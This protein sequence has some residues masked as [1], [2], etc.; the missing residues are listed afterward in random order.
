MAFCKIVKGSE[1][2]SMFFIALESLYTIEMWK[3][4]WREKKKRKCVFI[5]MFNKMVLLPVSTLFHATILVWHRIQTL[6]KAS[7]NHT[8]STIQ[9][10]KQFYQKSTE[11]YFLSSLNSAGSFLIKLNFKSQTKSQWY[12][13][14]FIS[15][16]FFPL[17][18][19]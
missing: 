10:W 7:I 18:I 9:P 1:L 15:L 13:D 2:L 6:K 14:I 3:E 16:I 5:R 8:N 11:R 19:S 17:I 12:Q 4:R